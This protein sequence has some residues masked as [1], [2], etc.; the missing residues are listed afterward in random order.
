MGGALFILVALGAAA[1]P[2]RQVGAGGVIIAV[3]AGGAGCVAVAMALTTQVTLT[4]AE[5]SYRANLRRSAIPWAAVR[6]FRVGRARAWGTW[7][8]IVVEVSGRGDVRIPITG[9]RPYVERVLGEVEAY[10]AGLGADVTGV[11]PA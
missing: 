7:S 9:S 2:W 11:T 6:S 4:P 1:Q 3:L 8:C 10:R 5:I